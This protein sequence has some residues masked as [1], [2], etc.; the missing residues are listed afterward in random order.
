MGRSRTALAAATLVALAALAGG[1]A[2]SPASGRIVYV[3][4]TSVTG[5]ARYAI[6]V[7]DLASATCRRLRLLGAGN[8]PPILSPT[9]VHVATV[10]RGRGESALT[11]L[12]VVDLRG[13]RSRLVAAW[14]RGLAFDAAWSADGR[15]LAYSDGRRLSVVGRDGRG[16]RSVTRANATE[17]AWSPDG[18]R[19]AFA[20]TTGGGRAG[21]LRTT[22]DVVGADG[23]GRRTLYVDE[24][25]YGSRPEPAWSPDAATLAFAVAEPS[26]IYAVPAGGGTPT[27]LALGR[28]PI[29]SPDGRTIA[30][31]RR[32][33]VDNVWTMAADGSRERRLTSLRTPPR[34]VPRVGAYP[35]AWSPDG[36][37][38][39][40]GRRWAL[41]TMS[42]NGSDKRAA[43]SSPAGVTVGPA[44]WTP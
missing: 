23:R 42:A 17:I 22:L 28:S 14:R 15:R 3:A 24:N 38:I 41:A 44:A 19:L 36:S 6:A 43:C 33:T 27:L 35:L 25:P 39:A 16:R 37:R 21:T 4:P 10:Q 12:R 2:G 20:A 7:A 8:W 32:G 26:R 11:Q 13:G 18:A 31:A 40:Y 1:A 34:G 9:G 29:W 30:F 5:P